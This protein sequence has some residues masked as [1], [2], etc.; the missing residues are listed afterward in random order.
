MPRVVDGDNVLG[1]WPGRSRSDADKRRLVREVDALMRAE[2]RRIVIVFDGTAPPGVSYGP[3][4]TFSGPGRKADAVILDLLR[5]EKDVAGWTVVT[6]DR[7]LA[8][9]CRWLGASIE[10]TRELRTK[11]SRD[12][13]GEKPESADDVAYWL[14]AFGEGKDN[15]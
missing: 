3:D 9:Q 6:S 1:T 2:R 15:D 11:L 14:K 7:A 12:S 10:G 5:R 4:V 8:D 13:A